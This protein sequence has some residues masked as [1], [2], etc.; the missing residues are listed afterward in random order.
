MLTQEKQQLVLS[1]INLA[2]KLISQYKSKGYDTNE[3][4]SAI[5]YI[6]CLSAD[7][8][9]HSKNVKFS[10]YFYKSVYYSFSQFYRNDVIKTPDSNTAK[11][12]L[13]VDYL[14]KSCERNKSYQL[15][16]EGIDLTPNENKIINMY[17][18]E[19]YKVTEIARIIGLHRVSV[20]NI[21]KAAL[22]KIERS[23]TKNSQ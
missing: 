2:K 11:K 22:K 19:N 16:L 13:N 7:K 14:Q 5:N 1:N 20:H 10:T 9:D 17:F 15:D 3:T 4:E 18:V 21:K 12:I 6:L 23:Y 8:F